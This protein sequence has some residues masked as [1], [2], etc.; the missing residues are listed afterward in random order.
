MKNERKRVLIIFLIIAI[1]AAIVTVSVIFYKVPQ[2]TISGNRIAVIHIN[3]PISSGDDNFNG[4]L[5]A[6]D[7]VNSGSIVQFIESA[8]KDKTIKGIILNINSPGGAVVASKDITEAVKKVDKPVVALIREVGASGAYW[9]ASA[10]DIIVAD[11]LS[12][13]GS[14]GVFG[15]YLE[16]S[17]L[18]SNYG[19]EFHSI[20]SGK[21]KDLGNQFVNLTPEGEKILEDKLNIIHDYFVDDVN[22]NRKKDLSKYAN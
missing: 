12:I 13:T 17:E 16:F 6:G 11:P 19:V 22:G 7:S 1:I 20:K 4:G 18:M 14:I 2:G 15:G 5:L 21:Y 9:V 10:A 3:G 8:S